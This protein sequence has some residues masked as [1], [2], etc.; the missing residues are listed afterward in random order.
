MSIAGHVSRRKLEHY[1]CIPTDANRTALDAIAQAP[2]QAIFGVGAV[3]PK[4]KT[5]FLLQ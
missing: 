1:S 2:N 4:V 3:D 5:I